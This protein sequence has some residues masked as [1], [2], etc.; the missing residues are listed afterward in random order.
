MAP[1]PT[2]AARPAPDIDAQVLDYLREGDSP[3]RPGD[4]PRFKLGQ[5]VRVRDVHPVEHTRLPGYLRNQIGTVDV[6]YDGSYG[7]FFSTGP[8][9]IGA[10][11]PVYCVKFE[12]KAIWGELA[13]PNSVIYADLFQIYLEPEAS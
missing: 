5:R 7:Y 2:A 9:G 12:P 8:D 6:V 13:E 3:K 11:M 4:P 10:P 1:Q